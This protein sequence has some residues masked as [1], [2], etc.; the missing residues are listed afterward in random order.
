MSPAASPPLLVIGASGHA[1]SL[2]ALLRRHRGFTPVGLIDS[3][4][5]AGPGPDGVPVLGAEGD[6][7]DL[8]RRLGVRHLLVAIGDNA[9]REAMTQRLVRDAPDAVFPALI[10]PTAVVA[11]GVRIGAGVVVLA[12]AHVGPGSELA[13]GVLLNTKASLDHDS[14]MAAF[15]SLAPGVICGGRVALGARSFIG[16]GSHLVAG[17]EIGADTVLGAGSLLLESLPAGVLAYGRPAQ[18][19]R[20]RRP[21][22]PYL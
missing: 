8:C 9:R 21:D 16:L 3:F 1:R 6:V 12:Q 13:D 2:L 5:P 15:A 22:E 18:V 14:R 17:L 20:S 11:P 10:D 7:P 19:I 4:Q